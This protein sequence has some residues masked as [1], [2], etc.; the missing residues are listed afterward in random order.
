[1]VARHN[2]Y[3]EEYFESIDPKE[4]CSLVRGLE[5]LKWDR[6]DVQD[7]LDEEYLS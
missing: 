3:L 6:N 1:M 5:D 2:K 4:E 7:Y